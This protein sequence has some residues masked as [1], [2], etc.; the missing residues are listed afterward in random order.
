MELFVHYSFLFS[1]YSSPLYIFL[2]KHMYVHVN[3]NSVLHL[4]NNWCMIYNLNIFIW[5]TQG[6]GY[7]GSSS[8][9]GSG[10]RDA[11]ARAM[12]GWHVQRLYDSGEVGEPIVKVCRNPYLLIHLLVYLLTFSTYAVLIF[13]FNF[14]VNNILIGQLSEQYGKAWEKPQKYW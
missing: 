5:I 9:P 13:Y 6:I 14:T 3:I 8:G 10:R 2:C 12:Q 4:H 11:A 7:D 1:L